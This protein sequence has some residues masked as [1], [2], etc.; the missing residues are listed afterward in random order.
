[1]LQI[2]NKLLLTQCVK[3]DDKNYND[4]FKAAIQVVKWIKNKPAYAVA[5]N[6]LNLNYRFFVVK[7]PKKLKIESDIY[8]NPMYKKDKGSQIIKTNEQCLSYPG[9]KFKKRRYERIEFYYYDPRT[10]E[11]IEG[12]A[13]GLAAIVIQHEI[14]HLNGMDETKQYHLD[15][16]MPDVD[17]KSEGDNDSKNKN[18]Q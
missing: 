7:K 2:N 17:T 11:H 9:I 8:F 3:I 10:K 15:E 6:Q 18:T 12:K 13:W 1:M 14:D 5:A 16:H 4:A